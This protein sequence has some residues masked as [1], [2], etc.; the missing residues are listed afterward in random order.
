M[1]AKKNTTR[2]P[3][4]KRAKKRVAARKAGTR[5]SK[6]GRK[7]AGKKTTWRPPTGKE[8]EKLREDWDHCT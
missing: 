7:R 6:P 1:P 4:T 2:G 3:R 8:L 5:G